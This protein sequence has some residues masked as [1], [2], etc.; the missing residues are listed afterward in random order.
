MK[1]AHLNIWERGR[2]LLVLHSGDVVFSRSLFCEVDQR[3]RCWVRY[4]ETTRELLVFFVR[5]LRPV[6]QDPDDLL[7]EL[8]VIQGRQLLQRTKVSQINSEMNR[9]GLLVDPSRRKIGDAFI[10]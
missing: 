9:H 10:L 1:I 2:Q 3:Q 8:F 6:G 4:T 7:V 5:E